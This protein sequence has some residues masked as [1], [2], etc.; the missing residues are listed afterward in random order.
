MTYLDEAQIEITAVGCLS[1]SFL[2]KLLSGEIRVKDA[3]KF[4]EDVR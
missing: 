3:E 2:P 4:A 1:G